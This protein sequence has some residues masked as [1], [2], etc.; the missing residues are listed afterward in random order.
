METAESKRFIYQFGKFALDPQ[1]KTLFADG[2]PRRLPAK[3][4]ET[5]IGAKAG[6]CAGR[7]RQGGAQQIGLAKPIID[8]LLAFFQNFRFSGNSFVLRHV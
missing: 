7:V 4:F 8:R 5:L 1:E 2:V 3:E 6:L